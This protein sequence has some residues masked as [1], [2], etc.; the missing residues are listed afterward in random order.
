MSENNYDGGVKRPLD[1][2]VKIRAKAKRGTGTRDQDEIV[3]EGRGEDADEAAY[4]FEK[5]LD[6]AEREGWSERLRS[7]QPS[8]GDDE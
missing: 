8:E 2:G 5:A 7:L 6:Y 1:H 3:I 4:D